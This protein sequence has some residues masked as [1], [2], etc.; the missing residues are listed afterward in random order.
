MSD[1]HQSYSRALQA[2]TNVHEADGRAYK[3][4]I[5]HGSLVGASSELTS[6]VSAQQTRQAREGL[7]AA[8][9]VLG[10]ARSMLGARQNLHLRPSPLAMTSGGKI[11]SSE[12]GLPSLEAEVKAFY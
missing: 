7:V 10:A 3:Y 4:S 5:E 2:R 12:S 1:L 9:L 8:E 11:C 6:V